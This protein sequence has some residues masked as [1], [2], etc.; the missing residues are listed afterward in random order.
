MTDY[1]MPPGQG[2]AGATDVVTQLR[3]IVLQ[4]SNWVKAFSGRQIFGSFT[5]A[6]SATTTV[7]NTSV[8]AN[9]QVA[10]FPANAGAATLMGSAKC[11][12]VSS[13][14]AGTSF[15]VSTASGAAAAGTET[16]NY[17]ITT[18]M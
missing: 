2:S 11:P 15:V 5:F 10:L 18:P 16:F 4:L 7:N 9:S 1:F 14:S 12:Y 6:A 17:I 13:I 3:G 8:A